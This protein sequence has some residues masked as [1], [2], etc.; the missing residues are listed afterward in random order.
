M[1]RENNIFYKV[2]WP[3]VVMFLVLI[4]IGWVN[5]YAA[6]YS[7]EHKSIFDLSQ[8]YGRQMIW[9]LTSLLLALI[10]LLF[11][12]KFFTAFSFPIYLFMI[13]LLVLVLFAGKVVAGSHSW[14]RIGA[15]GFQPSEFAKVG[16]TLALARYL[17]SMD[18]DL[19][20][21]KTK[22][23]A[24]LI[25]LCPTLLI[26]LEHDTGSAITYAAFFLVFFRE[27]MPGRLLIIGAAVVALFVMTLLIDK[28]I[29][30]GIVT[31]IALLSIFFRRITR[32]RILTT[33]GLFVLAAGL[34]LSVN[35]AFGHLLK[36]YQQ[37]RVYAM[38]SANFDPRGAGYNLNQSKIAIGSG[39]LFGKGF[40]KGTQTKFDFVPEQSTDFI[41]CT[42]GEEWGFTGCLIVIA[43]YTGLLIRIIQ[44]SERQRSVYSRIY[45]YSLASIL[46][47]HFMV[48]IGMT[49]GLAPVIGIPLPFLSYGGSSLWAFTA[50]LFIFIKLDTNRLDLI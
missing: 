40:L 20:K 21:L 4:V 26:L 35:Y 25:M 32:R 50:L 41:F 34:I 19:R 23:F 39:G 48:N 33:L 22:I 9:M 46:F 5:I 15:F 16:T 3:L 18:L 7:E 36:P 13:F 38:L 49:I 45:G 30:L 14:F 6:V 2:D 43:L 42:V 11:D 8:N 24:L 44:L 47:F 28:F 1:K 37:S 17:S 10:I 12:S 27:G 29:L 31:G